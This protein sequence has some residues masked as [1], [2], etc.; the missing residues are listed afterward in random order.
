MNQKKAGV[1]LSYFS[2]AIKILSSLLYTPIVLRL[3]G[4]SEYGLYQLVYSVVGYLALLNL[5]FTGSYT[6]YYYKTKAEGTEEDVTNLNG[7]FMT[8]FCVISLICILCGVVLVKN[9]HTVFGTGLTEAEYPTARILMIIMIANL[10]ITFPNSVFNC[11]FRS[12]N[13]ITR[14]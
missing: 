1:L 14:I 11:I 13:H 2:E 9:I 10:A 4:Q 7:M 8:I 12:I 3:L 5:G 6:R